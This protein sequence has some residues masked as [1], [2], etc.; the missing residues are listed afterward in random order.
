M[1][2]YSVVMTPTPSIEWLNAL[3]PLGLRIHALVHLLT[4]LHSWLC[5]Y[6]TINISETVEDTA[7]ITINDLY[8]IVGLHGLSIAAKMLL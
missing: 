6:K 2:K 8:K 3:Y 7:E 4:Y 5:A 1:T